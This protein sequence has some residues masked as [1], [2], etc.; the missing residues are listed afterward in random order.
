MVSPENDII[1]VWVIT[2]NGVKLA[3]TLFRNLARADVY[4]SKKIIYQSSWRDDGL[5]HIDNFRTNFPHIKNF[6]EKIPK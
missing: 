3:E 1:A 2:P 4:I 5:L 6:N